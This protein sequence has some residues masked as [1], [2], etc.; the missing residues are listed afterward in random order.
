MPVKGKGALIGEVREFT[1]A[2]HSLT[3]PKMSESLTLINRGCGKSK[4]VHD[5]GDAVSIT[6]PFAMVPNEIID[7]LA[8]HV[9]R[10]DPESADHAHGQTLTSLRAKAT[11]CGRSFVNLLLSAR[12]FLVVSESTRYEAVARLRCCMPHSV[13]A[14]DGMHPFAAQAKKEVRS[15][16]LTREAIICCQRWILHSCKESSRAYREAQNAYWLGYKTRL[17]PFVE[18]ALQQQVPQLR[19]GWT[20][21][22]MLMSAG[23]AWMPDSVV[24]LS[25]NAAPAL[26]GDTELEIRCKVPRT[27]GKKVTFAMTSGDLLAICF[28]GL[29][30][31][32]IPAM[33]VAHHEYQVWRMP[34]IGEP[35]LIEKKTEEGDVLNAHLHGNVFVA[36]VMGTVASRTH[37]MAIRTLVC[38]SGLPSTKTHILELAPRHAARV[39]GKPSFCPQTGNVAM[40]YAVQADEQDRLLTQRLQYYDCTWETGRAITYRQSDVDKY[41]CVGP[42]RDS[43]LVSPTGNVLANFC[44]SKNEM[45]GLY[46]YEK[47][48]ENGRPKWVARAGGAFANLYPSSAH[49]VPGV[50]LDDYYGYTHDVFSPCGSLLV[51][52]KA[53]GYS[54]VLVVNIRESLLNRGDP[55]DGIVRTFY[56]VG[57]NS[58]PAMVCWNDEGMWLQTR[59]HRGIL[60]LGLHAAAPTEPPAHAAKL[61]Q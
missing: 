4:V 59:V 56:G 36:V 50:F 10:V 13:V 26:S 51:T 48:T 40:L 33:P 45:P 17:G 46:L 60:H 16:M 44:R 29:E 34:L 43:V 49:A 14:D 15:A 24:V 54:G 22:G 2:E 52:M 9:L 38:G 32:Q 25:S 8:L 19:I 28:E 1:D 42:H 53:G 30:G 20:R 47:T 21:A 11:A 18:M 37:G 61:A 35:E 31:A 23:V 55:L 5:G 12:A 41:D 57:G 27:A 7:L 3:L 6:G 39:Y 58:I